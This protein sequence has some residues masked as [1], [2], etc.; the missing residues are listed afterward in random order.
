M[1]HRLACIL[2]LFGCA[3]TIRGYEGEP[4]P[5]EETAVI[6]SHS[7]PAVRIQIAELDGQKLDRKWSQGGR[8]ELRPGEHWI[9]LDV[10]WGALGPTSWLSVGIL[11]WFAINEAT[12][13][14]ATADILVHVEAGKR[15]VLV[16]RVSS[17]EEALY[18]ITDAETGAHVAGQRL[19]GIFAF[20]GSE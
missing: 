2:L 11:P 5:A 16:A 7:A 12:A 17:E 4:L 15:Y 14:H 3:G 20:Q 6:V 19:P 13:R 9:A 10:T 1:T 18:E 8:L